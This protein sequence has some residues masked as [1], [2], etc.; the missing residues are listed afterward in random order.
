MGK[1]YALIVIKDNAHTLSDERIRASFALPSGSIEE[2]VKKDIERWKY[3]YK[4]EPSDVIIDL[5]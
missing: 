3:K 4:E 1:K 5:Y 2:I